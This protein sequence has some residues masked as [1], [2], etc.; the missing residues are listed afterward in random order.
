MV[1]P[2]YLP[3]DFKFRDPS[4][5][6]KAHY[7]ALLEH[8]YGRQQNAKINIAF[9]FKGYWDSSS[10][11]VLGSNDSRRLSRRSQPKP[12]RA[13]SGVNASKNRPGPPGIRA[14]DPGFV[15]NSSSSSDGEDEDSEGEDDEDDHPR[16]IYSKK[17]PLDLPFAAKQVRYSGSGVAGLHLHK[18]RT[19]QSKSVNQPREPESAKIIPAVVKGTPASKPT[20]PGSKGDV[21]PTQVH[22]LPAASPPPIA[23]KARR[24]RY[25]SQPPNLGPQFERPATRHGGK[26]KVEAA[27]LPET[28]ESKTKRVKMDTTR[29]GGK[30][31]T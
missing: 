25:L 14:G 2:K 6:K 26:R 17:S 1:D 15:F 13:N 5:M 21:F 9:E 30:G 20:S 28:K 12:K 27:G 16:G 8:W 19:K 29:N 18:K 23:K 3:A 22:P 31:E 7:Q 24:P 10:E 4:K 11:S